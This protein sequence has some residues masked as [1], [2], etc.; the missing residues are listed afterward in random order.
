VSH[1]YLKGVFTVYRVLGDRFSALQTFQHFK[2]VIKLMWCCT[3]LILALGRLR[4][5]DTEFGAGLGF[6]AR[7]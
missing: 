1:A 3:S 4:Q 5:K 6:I 2:D 7:L